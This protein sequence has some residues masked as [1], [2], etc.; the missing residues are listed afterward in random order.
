MEISAPF[1]GD[2]LLHDDGKFFWFFFKFYGLIKPQKVFLQNNDSSKYTVAN[3]V[4]P[5][6]LFQIDRGGVTNNSS[7]ATFYKVL[8]PDDFTPN[9]GFD[10]SSN[11]VYLYT[12]EETI[13]AINKSIQSVKKVH[14]FILNT[15]TTTTVLQ[16]AFLVSWHI[17]LWLDEFFSA[18]ATV[19][20]SEIL[21]PR[22][23]T[24]F[25]PIPHFCEHWHCGKYVV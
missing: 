17:S 14:F 7:K 16:V 23:W 25:Q 18:R 2:L 15:C 1:A 9:Y 19:T 6:F 3:E 22:W 21:C 10:I 13:D 12:I 20:H 4:G 24:C 5:F 8:Y 11:S